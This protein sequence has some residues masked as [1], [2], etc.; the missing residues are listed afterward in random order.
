MILLIRK[1]FYAKEKQ[2]K[3][4]PNFLFESPKTPYEDFFKVDEIINDQETQG[5]L[6]NNNLSVQRCVVRKDGIDLFFYAN[7]NSLFIN[8][9]TSPYNVHRAINKSIFND[10]VKD[11]NQV[12]RDR[13]D[14]IGLQERRQKD[15]F[16]RLIKDI[17]ETELTL[18]K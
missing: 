11:Y 15:Q 5:Y 16:M 3:R 14:F 12:N 6:I 13:S 10:N 8:N 4:I 2:Q 7:Q 9:A 18:E 17:K 1:N